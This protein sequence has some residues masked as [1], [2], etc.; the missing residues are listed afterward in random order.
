MNKET[1]TQKITDLQ[2]QAK[3]HELAAIQISGA[4][5]ILNQLIKELEEQDAPSEVQE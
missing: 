4:I 2:N 3:Q 5:Q 1:L